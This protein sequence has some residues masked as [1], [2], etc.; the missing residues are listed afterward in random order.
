MSVV[1]RD[2][3][4]RAL[5]FLKTS[6]RDNT[7]EIS[8][9]LF[10]WKSVFSLKWYQQN[11]EAPGISLRD[12]WI[13]LFEFVEF[14]DASVNIAAFNCIGALLIALSPFHTTL[15]IETFGSV[16]G[17]LAVLPNTS[18]AVISSFIFLSHQIGPHKI[19]GFVEA[20]PV[21]HHFGADLRQFIH[22]VPNLVA[23]MSELD[24]GFHKALLRSLITSFARAPNSH[25]IDSVLSLL[26]RFP[27]PLMGDLM[28]FIESNN[29]SLTLLACGGPILKNPELAKCLSPRQKLAIFELAESELG[30][31]QAPAAT[32]EQA[33][34]VIS[35]MKAQPDDDLRDVA[36]RFSLAI[37]I[38]SYKPHVR[39]LLIPLTGN[40]D[41]LCPAEDDSPID[42]CV[43]IA[44]MANFSPGRDEDI[45]NI[46]DEYVSR[47]DQVFLAVVELLAIRPLLLTARP[48]I[49]GRILQAKDCSWVQQNAILKVIGALNNCQTA[50]FLHNPSYTKKTLGYVLYCALSRQSIVAQTARSVLDSILGVHNV[51]V[52]IQQGLRVDFFDP[53]TIESFVLAL[54]VVMDKMLHPAFQFL[55]PV[56]RDCILASPDEA[57]VPKGFL[58]L[59]RL[60]MRQGHRALLTVCQRKIE[61]LF[62][63]YTQKRLLSNSSVGSSPLLSTMTT[64]IVACPNLAV[65]E[66]LEPLTDC[67]HYFMRFSPTSVATYSQIVLPLLPLLP[68]Q[69]LTLANRY[70][71]EVSP[72]DV[73]IV[74]NRTKS[75]GVVALCCELL[76]Q[77]PSIPSVEAVLDQWLEQG[78]V[79]SPAL[80]CALARYF[81]TR[82]HERALQTAFSLL[83]QFPESEEFSLAV[84]LYY[85]QELDIRQTLYVKYP[86]LLFEVQPEKAREW[87]LTHSFAR[88][89]LKGLQ[90][91]PDVI[92]KLLS[93][94]S[95]KVEIGDVEDA[96][97]VRWSFI[98]KYRQLFNQDEVTKY[99]KRPQIKKLLKKNLAASLPP[100]QKIE[101]VVTVS[102]E[103]SAAPFLRRNMEIDSPA[104]IKAFL[105][106]SGVRIS[107]QQFD[108]LYSKYP[109]LVASFEKYAIRHDLK[110]PLRKADAGIEKVMVEFSMK[111]KV[112]SQICR[113]ARRTSLAE[114]EVL[115]MLMMQHLSEL[116][117]DKRWWYFLRFLRLTLILDEHKIEVY[118]RNTAEWMKHILAVFE[119]KSDVIICELCSLL[120]YLFPAEALRQHIEQWPQ[121]G[122]VLFRTVQEGDDFTEV[123]SL[124]LEIVRHHNQFARHDVVRLLEDRRNIVLSD[125]VLADEALKFLTQNPAFIT[126]VD[127]YL[128]A[129]LDAGSPLFQMGA[130]L[131]AAL[132][133]RAST[134]LRNYQSAIDMIPIK[135]YSLPGAM[136]LSSAFYRAMIKV[137]EASE[138]AQRF[139]V[140]ELRQIADLFLL[141]PSVGNCQH[142]SKTLAEVSHF[143]D[144]VSGVLLGTLIGIE[145]QFIFVL[146]LANTYFASS[147][148]W[149]QERF[150]AVL[151][152]TEGLQPRSRKLALI[153]MAE[154]R[155][156]EAFLFAAA[157]TDD[158][159]ILEAIETKFIARD[160]ANS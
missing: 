134:S 158:E 11:Y 68:G 18:I 87:F 107:Q 119:P 55:G 38:A 77:M 2:Q 157:E 154:R 89:P 84:K 34:T 141:N 28:E 155:I 51:E 146:L 103:C 61:Q 136:T 120:S 140:Q 75:Q 93:E 95:Q 12:V 128:S 16:V 35:A 37:Q 96:E 72:T 39:R 76:S 59:G 8:H 67:F 81:A 113:K 147:V 47:R 142:I 98:M 1:V 111:A 82:D 131:A 121:F 99:F 19:S 129:I 29:L 24:V 149:E 117:S 153:R 123:P 145:G 83:Q 48:T 106:F 88:W 127:V 85:Q 30:N 23:R 92:V 90:I 102:T 126:K 151:G 124:I 86:F 10:E 42:L 69:I 152:Q 21:L 80:A 139:E 13:L 32:Y 66:F 101:P 57:F 36:N 49:L 150:V 143:V 79:T 22:H 100:F 91:F 33:V 40:F 122:P 6:D 50:P 133:M 70:K 159:A 27:E 116:K 144:F 41:D 132:M 3:H 125:F 97:R 56:V 14:S 53:K 4:F 71:L 130:P 62:W 156:N 138:S 73:E 74:L 7:T 137:F 20:I 25:F 46:C 135:G 5:D 31:D 17:Q 118:K 78:L 44:A 9:L 104:L 112:L 105:L 65:E 45:L 160:E 94:G 26:G 52:F 43:K 63:G 15:L 114:I 60:Q 54:N 64:D 108:Q 148:Q 110:Y 109:K 58:F 115:R